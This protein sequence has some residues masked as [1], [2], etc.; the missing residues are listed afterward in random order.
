MP[1]VLPMGRQCPNPAHRPHPPTMGEY[2]CTWFG[3]PAFIGCYTLHNRHIEKVLDLSL[4]MICT[5]SAMISPQF[6]PFSVPNAP[7]L[8]PISSANA[9]L[10]LSGASDS[11]ILFTVALPTCLPL[12][13]PLCRPSPPSL[14][15][16]CLLSPLL[17]LPLHCCR[18]FHCCYCP[19]NHCRYCHRVADARSIAVTIAPTIVAIAIAV[20]VT[21]SIAVA[22]VAIT[23]PLHRPLPLLLRCHGT[24]HYCCHCTGQPLPP[25]LSRR[26][27]HCH[28][29]VCHH[30]AVA[31]LIA[32]VVAVAIVPS[33]AIAVAVVAVILPLCPPSSWPSSRRHAV[34]CHHY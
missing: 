3:L 8:L 28:C 14:L 6:A 12:P 1:I 11:L 20:T 10:V 16:L 13:L 26:A 21:P 5:A 22:I 27:F 2:P 30:V 18:A 24:F 17:L 4:D 15:P 29:R 32:V 23:L 33:I 9:G 25:L 7:T 19:T 31:P 34:H